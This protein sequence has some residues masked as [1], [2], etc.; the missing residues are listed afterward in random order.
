MRGI[1]INWLIEVCF[2]MINIFLML[3]E[4]FSCFFLLPPFFQVHLRFD[5]MQETLFLMV[6]LLD[7]FLSLVSIG[8]NKMQLVGLTALLLASKYEDFWH[9]RVNLCMN[10]TSASFLYIIYCCAIEVVNA[11]STF[12]GSWLQIMDL[13]GISADSYT[14]DE[15]LGMVSELH[16]YNI[17]Q[18]VLI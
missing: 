18:Q 3:F 12:F 1:L 7:Q 14:R 10:T 4:L 9:P 13:I 6:T 17:Y 8:K 16:V 11:G 15:M 5:L 2:L